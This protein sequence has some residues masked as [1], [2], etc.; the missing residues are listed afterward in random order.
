VIGVDSASFV[1]A[2]LCGQLFPDS[3]RKE[4]NCLGLPCAIDKVRIDASLLYS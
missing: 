1:N 4:V 3:P 2:A